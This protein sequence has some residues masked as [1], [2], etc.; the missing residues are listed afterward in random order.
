MRVLVL[1]GTHH[2]GRNV[3]EAALTRGDEVTTLNR[4]ISASAPA[5]VRALTADRTQL[6]AA[7][8]AL[9]GLNFDVVVDTW[10]GAPRAVA[11]TAEALVDCA[12][13]YVY[14]SSRSVHGWPMASHLDESGPTV[15]A[16]ADSDDRSDYAAA[17]RGGELAA[18]RA[19]GART[20]IARPGLII[21]P[22]EMV[23]RLPWWLTRM[24]RGGDVLCPGPITRPLQYIDG[25]DLAE[26]LLAASGRGVTGT[27]N[28]VSQ[29]GHATIGDLL[30]ECA[31][32]AGP[33]AT[34]HWLTPEQIDDAGLEGWMQLPIWLPPDGEA[35]ALH[36]G[37]VTKAFAHGLSC[38]PVAETVASTYDWMTEEGAPAGIPGLGLDPARETEV[39]AALNLRP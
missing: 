30:S 23:G 20:L 39:L 22:Y 32:V 26:W 2:V 4:G 34:L 21:G 24:E 5:G 10:S 17:K 12:Q 31:R 36:D 6:G 29:P 14:V 27:F 15:D 8:E 7:R 38:R 28:T 33:N 11:E 13:S 16:D 9:A 19:F 25:R 35:A 37:D 1:G 18:L 3:V